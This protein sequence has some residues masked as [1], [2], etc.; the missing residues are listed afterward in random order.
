MVW[1][2][3]KFTKNKKIKISIFVIVKQ[4]RKNVA[5]KQV[6]SEKVTYLEWNLTASDNRVALKYKN[7]G[8]GPESIEWFIE[9]QA[10]L[11]PY[12]S[13]PCPP[14]LPHFSRQ[15]VVSFS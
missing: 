4:V 10:F 9:D 13:A 12:D 15:Q 3:T 8:L 7:I 14:P 6:K 2:N 11:R 1:F 5:T